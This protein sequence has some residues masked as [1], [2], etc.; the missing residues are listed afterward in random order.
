MY[1]VMLEQQC[2]IKVHEE[3]RLVIRAHPSL[4]QAE[5]VGMKCFDAEARK[6]LDDLPSM[7]PDKYP[8]AE[9]ESLPKRRRNNNDS[10]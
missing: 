10:E 7:F 8:L 1:C 3:N 9:R 2:G 5:I 4:P 6:I